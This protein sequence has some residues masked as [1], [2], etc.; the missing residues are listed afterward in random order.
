MTQLFC[1]TSSPEASRDRAAAFARARAPALETGRVGHEIANRDLTARR[2]QRPAFAHHAHALE[3]RD[4]LRH[5]I[6]E[7]DL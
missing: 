5:R 3:G 1:P 7:L 4:E 6:G 2:H